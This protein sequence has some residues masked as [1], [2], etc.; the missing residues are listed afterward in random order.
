MLYFLAIKNFLLHHNLLSDMKNPNLNT[1]NNLHMGPFFLYESV[2][3]FSQ[4][5]IKARHLVETN[6]I[7]CNAIGPVIIS[8]IFQNCVRFW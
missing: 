8:F 3:V 4:F 6:V 5:Q 2:V 1:S 7:K